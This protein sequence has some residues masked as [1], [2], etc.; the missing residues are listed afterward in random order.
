MN[1]RFPLLALTILLLFI[2][3]SADAQ[4]DCAP[5]M[6]RQIHIYDVLVKVPRPTDAVQLQR[7]R[8]L[9]L[10]TAGVVAW[11]QNRYNPRYTNGVY[12][13]SVP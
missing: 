11:F 9:H 6:Y 13:L 3:T 12:Q 5:C 1:Y 2:A 8:K 7:W 10:I 4:V